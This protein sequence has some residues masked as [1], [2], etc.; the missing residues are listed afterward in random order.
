MTEA[1]NELDLRVVS[2]SV[3]NVG[4][5]KYQPQTDSAVSFPPKRASSTR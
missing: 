5:N 4:V 2:V 3:A 1:L